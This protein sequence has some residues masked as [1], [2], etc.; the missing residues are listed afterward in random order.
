MSP[1]DLITDGIALPGEQHGH[2][3]LTECFDICYLCGCAAVSVSK[4]PKT[5]DTGR[6][7]IGG[8]GHGQT[9]IPRED[10]VRSYDEIVGEVGIAVSFI[11]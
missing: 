8:L 3:I 7:M 4:Y 10:A 5:A 6:G 9:E 2:G 11:F 1:Q